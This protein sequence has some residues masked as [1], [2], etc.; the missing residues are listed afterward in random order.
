MKTF[1]AI[2]PY[3]KAFIGSLVAGLGALLTALDDGSLSAQEI[4]TVIIAFLVAFGAVFAI[5]N[6]PPFVPP[7]DTT[8]N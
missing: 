3:A 2:A 8:P 6:K 5:P 1:E 7:S 4:V